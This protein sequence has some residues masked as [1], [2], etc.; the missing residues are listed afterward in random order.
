[1]LPWSLTIFTFPLTTL[2]SCGSPMQ[3][4]C[5]SGYYCET[6]AGNQAYDIN[7]LALDCRWYQDS[8]SLHLMAA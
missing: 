2:G 1:M 8:L 7:V 5:H 6:R 4:F 3:P